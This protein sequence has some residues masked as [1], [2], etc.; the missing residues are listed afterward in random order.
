MNFVSVRSTELLSKYFG[1][2]EASIRSVFKQVSNSLYELKEPRNDANRMIYSSRRL[3]YVCR[4][5]LQHHVLSFLM[6]LMHL[7]TNGKR[8]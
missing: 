1:Q 7:L 5:E 8:T 2:T 4:L 6:S 3:S